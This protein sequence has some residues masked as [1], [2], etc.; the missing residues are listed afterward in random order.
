MTKSQKKKN[1]F[2]DPFNNS[3]DQDDENSDFSDEF[4]IEE[5]LKEEPKSIKVTKTHGSN[6]HLLELKETLGLESYKQQ[7]NAKAAKRRRQKERKRLKKSMQLGNNANGKSDFVETLASRM[8]KANNIIPEVVTFKDPRKKSVEKM[9]ENINTTENEEKSKEKTGDKD[10]VTMKEARWD[11]YKFGTRGLDKKGQHD[12]RVTLAI[13]LGAKP[14]KNKCLPY[15]KYK[16][17]QKL[18]KEKSKK[19]LEMKKVSGLLKA[20]K[21][22]HKSLKKAGSSQTQFKNSKLQNNSKVHKKSKRSNDNSGVQPKIGKFDG[23]MLKLS[24]KDIERIKGS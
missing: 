18:E 8:G 16:E 6:K 11:V 24:K 12:A 23:G 3:S 15:E 13:S 20:S 10:E 22:S 21:R 1:D 5:N 19:E 9:S 2:I 14:E 7:V 17:Q 4:E